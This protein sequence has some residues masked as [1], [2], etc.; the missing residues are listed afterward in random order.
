MIRPLFYLKSNT[1]EKPQPILLNLVRKDGTSFR[2]SI[3][4]KILPELWDKET[5]RPTKN[6]AIL[7]EAKKSNPH[8]KALL[9]NIENRIQSVSS[10]VQRLTLEHEAS[11]KTVDY[12]KLKVELN[13]L[14]KSDQ[15]L[16]DNLSTQ[17][18]KDFAES[19]L[20][21][22]EK[23]ELRDDNGKVL[24]KTTVKSFKEWFSNWESFET[25]DYKR[26]VTFEAVNESLY[27]KFKSYFL[28]VRGNSR[29]TVGKNIK[30]LK[31]VMKLAL[32]EGYHENKAFQ[33]FKVPT[34]DTTHQ[35]LTLEEIEAI[36]DL[37]LNEAHLQRDRDVFLISCYTALRYSD[38]SRLS[39]E[40]FDFSNAKTRIKIIPQKTKKQVIIPVFE[41]CKEILEKYDYTLPRT[42]RQKVS[43]S[44]KEVCRR[45]GITNLVE[46]NSNTGDEE[47]EQVEKWTQ[48]STHTGR[49]TGATLL[50]K[51]G[52]PPYVIMQITGHKKESTFLHYINMSAEDAL[53]ILEEVNPFST[54]KGN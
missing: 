42:H 20:V 9:A 4:K 1:A 2:W 17:S 28:D 11:N 22:A 14:Y 53:Q 45:A 29:S 40:H 19:L 31:R 3:G 37:E 54:N 46:R 26:S 41:D 44:I 5:Q 48:I 38:V 6:R 21:K 47:I 7:N 39:N 10:D 51:A 34:S 12:E 16:E 24:A 52:I 25:K 23:G 49:R 8:L 30:F 15:K 27:K 32:K 50:Y 18:V 43:K 35:A 13:N 33:D 36:K